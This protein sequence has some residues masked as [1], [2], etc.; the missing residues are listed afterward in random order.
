MSKYK[1]RRTIGRKSTEAATTP[2]KKLS[3]VTNLGCGRSFSAKTK[4]IF[5]FFIL[6]LVTFVDVSV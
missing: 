5:F 3:L 1:R 2:T 6:F 4:V